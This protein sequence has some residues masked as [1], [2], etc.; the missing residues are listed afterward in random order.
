MEKNIIVL[1]VNPFNGNRGVGALA[2]STIYLLDKLSEEIKQP[3]NLYIVGVSNRINPV[4]I[5]IGTKNVRIFF[6]NL[7]VIIVKNVFRNSV[8]CAKP[9]AVK[10]TIIEPKGAKLTKLVIALPIMYFIPSPFNK[11]FIAIT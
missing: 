6:E 9:I 3:F 7:L 1:G 4:E 11:D 2:Y 5:F 8:F 10:A